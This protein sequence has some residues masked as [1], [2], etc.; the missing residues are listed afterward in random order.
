MAEGSRQ[1]HGFWHK[2]ALLRYAFAVLAALAA[3]V[4][5][6]A[7]TDEWKVSVYSILVGAVALAV[8][9]GGVGPGI[10]GVVLA[11]AGAAVFVVADHD[12]LDMTRRE[13]WAQWSVG[14][15]VAVGVIWVSLVLRRARVQAVQARTTP[16]IPGPTPPYHTASATAPTRIE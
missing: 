13:A 1:L 3:V 4:A 7:L 8:W 9:Y 11:W 10:V 5:Q 16:T 6:V 2:S 15:A 12:S 14:L